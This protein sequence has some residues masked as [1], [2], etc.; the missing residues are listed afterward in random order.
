MVL[1]VGTNFC[2]FSFPA[3]NPKMMSSG[4]WDGEECSDEEKQKTKTKE[5]FLFGGLF[6]PS[7][8]FIFFFLS[9]GGREG[10]F[11]LF[12]P[13]MFGSDETL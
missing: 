3:K 4:R 7:F 12:F 8:L 9:A 1:F 2:L 5:P 10:Y 6:F 13:K 11:V